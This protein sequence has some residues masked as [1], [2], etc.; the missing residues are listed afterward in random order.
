MTL[1]TVMKL[2]EDMS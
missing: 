2:T 1:A